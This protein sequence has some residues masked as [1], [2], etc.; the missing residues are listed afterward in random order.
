MVADFEI[1]VRVRDSNACRGTVRYVGPV[2]T[3][4]RKDV[5]WVGVE[6]DD[7]TR[8][9][10]DGS[11]VLENGKKVK[12]F[13]TT[14]RTGG[15]F[16]KPEK[17]T[18]GV[19]F[20]EALRKRYVD[21][22]APRL[23]PDDVF[24]GCFANTKRGPTKQI[25]FRGELKVRSVQ[26]LGTDVDRVSMRCADVAFLG[27][28]RRDDDEAALSKLRQV[29]LQCNLLASWQAVSDIAK[30][31]PRLVTLD[32]SGNRL[33]RVL[34]DYDLAP[35]SE[36]EHLS[37]NGCDLSCWEDVLRLIRAAPRLETLHVAS[38]PIS[39]PSAEFASSKLRLLDV[40][41]TRLASAS[42]LATAFPDLEELFASENPQL[43]DF[44]GISMPRVATL[45]VGSCG[46]ERWA[47]VDD[48]ARAFPNLS[49]LRFGL[50]NA[51][52]ANL[53]PSETRAF[54]LARLP[55]L[56]TLNGA[57]V[58]RKEI[59]EAEKRFLR[60]A[61]LKK[62]EEFCDPRRLAQLRASYPDATTSASSSSRKLEANLLDLTLTSLASASADAPDKR[63]KLPAST[64]VILL[65][66]LC[67]KHFDLDQDQIILFFRIDK[68]DLAAAK[69]DDDQAPLHYFGI[70]DR[71]T[72][73][74]ADKLLP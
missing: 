33:G 54:V 71:A 23:A 4:S 62:D 45:A 64:K 29:D 61:E 48:L 19:S 68:N 27:D 36:V 12:Y 74:V 37:A 22:D 8:G 14:E 28:D 15:S 46:L 24:E 21:M 11:V 72:I 13:E 55:Q 25:E 73:H 10:H 70:P 44:F 60:I 66:R 40:A 2:A 3:S 42:P 20:V 26:Q 38:N 47:A 30:G 63:V 9:K 18:L 35:L 65:K 58:S 53:G 32:V 5:V 69:L 67:S 39:P 17:L 56:D 16:V 51:V 49:S 1:G 31:L 50:D 41:K 7:G 52:S 57:S 43:R 59:C 34:A 6:W